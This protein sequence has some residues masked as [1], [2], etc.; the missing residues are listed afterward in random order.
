MIKSDKK[1]KELDTILN[2]G[3]ANKIMDAV[4]SLRNEIP[5]EGAI[6]L[7]IA[8]YDRSIDSTVKKLIREFL[9]DVKD[10]SVR[11]EI[12]GEIRKY[13]DSETLRMI[14]SSCWQSGLDYSDYTD[15]FAKIFLACDYL[16][17]IECFSVIETSAHTMSKIKRD[18]IIKMIR[19]SISGPADDKTALIHEL[20][21][22]LS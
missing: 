6:G 3:N 18:R 11:T 17:A 8:H 1:F 20:I 2:G 5:Y 9:N 13:G 4:K 22:V 14:I 19:E 21:T 10:Q 16:T 15:E 7:L 12:V